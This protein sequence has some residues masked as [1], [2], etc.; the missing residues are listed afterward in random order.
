M[1][2]GK[3]VSIEGGMATVL[4][5]YGEVHHFIVTHNSVVH[6]HKFAVGDKVSLRFST[7]NSRVVSVVPADFGP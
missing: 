5:S 4:M 1:H 7:D 2:I 3:I 6:G